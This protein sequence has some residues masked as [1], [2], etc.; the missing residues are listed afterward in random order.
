[1]AFVRS[2]L[3]AGWVVGALGCRQIL[4]FEDPVV[5]DASQPSDDDGWRSG[6]RLKLTW[7]DYD[8]AREYTGLYDSV[9]ETSCDALPWVD[10]KHYC[11][12]TVGG[13]SFADADC[14]QP[15]GV[16]LAGSCDRP[17]PPYFAKLETVACST[18]APRS[19]LFRRGAE[20]TR[21]AMLYQLTSGRC[22]GNTAPPN[23]DYYAL[24]EELGPD[25]LVEMTP[26]TVEMGRLQRNDFVGADGSRMPD[27][28]YDTTL[29]SAC[30][31]D[32]DNRCAPRVGSSGAFADNQCTQSLAAAATECPAPRYGMRERRPGCA[33]PGLE[34]Y[35]VGSTVQ[36]STLWQLNTGTCTSFAPS[37]G[38]NY[39]QLATQVTPASLARNVDDAPGTQIRALHY[40]DGMASL[41][42]RMFDTTH[43]IECSGNASVSR[44]LPTASATVLTYF[45]DPDCLVPRDFASVY[46]G[47]SACGNPRVP[48]FAIKNVTRSACM[49]SYEVY[50]IGNRYSSQVYAMNTACT[51]ATIQNGMLFELGA[52]EPLTSFAPYI[53]VI[54]P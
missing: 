9:L 42:G 49:Q 26:A 47:P 28:T 5:G 17:P 54:E 6:T 44:C 3:A 51:A 39:Y 11:L 12:P 53:E 46:S 20:T 10:G 37:A 23:L 32:A 18:A 21:P 48:M 27:E 40:T 22:T 14:T 30:T 24:E 35:T 33:D 52:Q 43:N 7:H 2:L 8:G 34:Y 25:A 1:M 19:G 29:D 4:G 36:S 45:T 16:W 41:R 15:I 13:I 31:I 38:F 50:R